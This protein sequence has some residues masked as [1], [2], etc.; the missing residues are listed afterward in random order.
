MV[1]KKEMPSVS[2]TVAALSICEY[3][4]W[5]GRGGLWRRRLRVTDNSTWLIAILFAAACSAPRVQNL[6]PGETD[7]SVVGAI[8]A[9][10]PAW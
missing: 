9:I 4:F 7:T 8:L 6:S 10:T 1:G 5:N 2:E 3:M